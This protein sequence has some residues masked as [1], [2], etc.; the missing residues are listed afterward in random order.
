MS[1]L[2]VKLSDSAA[3]PFTLS[4][5]ELFDLRFFRGSHGSTD[6][7]GYSRRRAAR[8]KADPTIDRVGD[9]PENAILPSVFAKGY[10]GLLI[11]SSVLAALQ[12]GAAIRALG[13]DPKQLVNSPWIVAT[14]DRANP[15]LIVAWPSSNDNRESREVSE[16][17]LVLPRVL[18]GM[19][20]D[21]QIEEL[22]VWHERSYLVK[23]TE[24]AMTDYSGTVSYFLHPPKPWLRPTPVEN[25]VSQQVSNDEDDKKTKVPSKSPFTLVFSND[26]LLVYIK[27]R[28]HVVNG[29]PHLP[30]FLRELKGCDWVN[31]QK[32]LNNLPIAAS[33]SS[34][35]RL[36]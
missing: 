3:F 20:A 15:G 31:Y 6:L 24:S 36:P 23:K 35:D 26:G 5:F 9:V 17:D 30:P 10:R 12:R 13:I 11:P 34:G 22:Y 29:S 7:K 19:R 1:P 14:N 8:D 28:Y 16:S 27:Y 21:L 18:T 25:L 32:S 2:T 4:D 33:R